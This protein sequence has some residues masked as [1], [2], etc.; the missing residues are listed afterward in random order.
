MF[1]FREMNV[2]FRVLWRPHESCIVLNVLKVTFFDGVWVRS[3]VGLGV[4]D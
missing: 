2:V 4:T 3:F 1:F